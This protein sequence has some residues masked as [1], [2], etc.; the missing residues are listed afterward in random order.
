M[1]CQHLYTYVVHMYTSVYK[2]T[3]VLVWTGP[4]PLPSPTPSLATQGIPS[5][6]PLLLLVHPLSVVVAGAIV[7]LPGENGIAKEL[8]AIRLPWLVLRQ[9]P[10]PWLHL[11]QPPQSLSTLGIQG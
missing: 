10:H 2:K 1:S 7:G 3:Y 8:P 11:L 5:T 4:P 9:P 6:L